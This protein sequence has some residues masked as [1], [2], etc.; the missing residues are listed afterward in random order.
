MFSHD[1]I[2]Q[3]RR[4]DGAAIVVQKEG[5]QNE[6]EQKNGNFILVLWGLADLI[7]GGIIKKGTYPCL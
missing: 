6:I 4:K 3:D 7:A 2:W 5:K 1:F